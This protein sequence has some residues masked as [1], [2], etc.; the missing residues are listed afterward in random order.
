MILPPPENYILPR[1]YYNLAKIDKLAHGEIGI[2][3]PES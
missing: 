3:L 1:L 2:G